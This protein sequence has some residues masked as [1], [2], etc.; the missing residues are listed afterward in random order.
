MPGRRREE[1]PTGVVSVMPQEQITV[2]PC[3]S[4][5]RIKDSEVAAPPRCISMGHENFHLPGNLL[6]ASST[7]NHTVGTPVVTVT[8][9]CSIKSSRPSASANGPFNTTLVP[10]I[11]A[12]KGIPQPLA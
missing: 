8:R 11:A 1:V 12:V 4:N 2:I 7:P 3:R 5:P 10:A 9:S 6:S